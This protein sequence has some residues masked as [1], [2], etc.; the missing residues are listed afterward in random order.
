MLGPVLT[1]LQKELHDVVISRTFEIA[2]RNGLLPPPPPELAG[3]D[4]RPEYI[5]MLATAQRM[6][7]SY[8]LEETASFVGAIT[9]IK[10]DAPDV[11][12]WDEAIR[13]QAD[14]KGVDPKL[15]RSEED[16]AAIRKQRAQQMAQQQAIETAATLAPAAKNFADI[17][18]DQNN[19]LS[20]VLGGARR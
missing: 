16:I 1:R 5:S 20:Q 6:V 12:D 11:L 9:A 19:A 10:P 2:S 13:M 4:F 17:P 14:M 7:G 3:T 8:G 18:L 15:I